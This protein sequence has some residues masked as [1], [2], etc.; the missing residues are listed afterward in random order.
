MQDFINQ[1]IKKKKGEKMKSVIKFCITTL[2]IIF[3]SW[4]GYSLGNGIASK[5]YPNYSEEEFK[6]KTKFEE[7]INFIDVKVSEKNQLS[8]EKE[9]FYIYH[10]YNDRND[11][12]TLKSKKDLNY[13]EYDTVQIK[14]IKTWFYRPIKQPPLPHLIPLSLFSDD[15]S[16]SVDYQYPIY[17]VAEGLYTDKSVF[18][19]EKELI[20]N[21]YSDYVFNTLYK[22]IIIGYI[23]LI[24]VSCGIAF[25]ASYVYY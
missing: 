12:G 8:S 25:L 9:D 23:I 5:V 14:E 1:I 3:S 16:L 13:E 11:Y 7:E 22:Y 10:F 18:F 24:F 20:D 17:E 15:V 19:E 6:K 4:C 21:A 2:I